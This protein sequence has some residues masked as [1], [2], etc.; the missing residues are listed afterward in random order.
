LH[1]A[2]LRTIQG[3]G[4]WVD[5]AVG[6][7]TIARSRLDVQVG[8]LWHHLDQSVK[9][10]DCHCKRGDSGAEAVYVGP[11]TCSPRKRG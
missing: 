6:Q 5:S 9:L 8:M 4:V 11:V 3:R 2:A 1:L 10:E 7:V